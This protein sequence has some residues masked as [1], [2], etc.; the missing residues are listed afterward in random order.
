MIILEVLTISSQ[1]ASLP[2]PLLARRLLPQPHLTWSD[3][4]AGAL[5]S[6]HRPHHRRQVLR[7]RHHLPAL[8]LLLRAGSHLLESAHL[9]HLVLSGRTRQPACSSPCQARASPSRCS[10]RSPRL[11]RALSSGSRS[12][13]P[14][15]L[16]PTNAGHGGRGRDDVEAKETVERL[17]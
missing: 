7:A 8:P 5:H 11:A 1:M 12:R 6:P 9:G 14:R 4:P 16:R 15:Y 2:P 17:I 10:N 3:Q 13:S